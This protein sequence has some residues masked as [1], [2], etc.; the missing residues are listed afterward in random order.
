MTNIMPLVHHARRTI[1]NLRTPNPDFQ[2]VA[3]EIS[4][5]APRTRFRP[6]RTLI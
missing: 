4:R 3:S 1:R 5:A 2:P 6:R